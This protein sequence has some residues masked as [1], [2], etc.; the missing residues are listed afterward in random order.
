MDNTSKLLRVVYGDFTLGVHGEG[1]DYIFSYAQGGLESLVKNGY[2]WLYRSPRPTFW[3]ALTDNDRGSK[4]HIKSGSWLAADMFIDCIDVEV[5]TDGISQGKTCAPDNN[6]YGG[7]LFAENVALK[8]VYRTITIPATTVEVRY[9]IDVEGKITVHVSYKGVEGLSELPV[10]GLRFIM[11]TLADKYM[12]EGLSGETYPDRMAGAEHGV[13]EIDDLSLTPYLVPQECG[14]RMNTDWLEVTRHTSLNNS[15]K[16]N[17]EQVLRIEKKDRA[18]AFSCLPYTASEIENAMHQE[19]L[20]SA[21]R[22]VLCVY[23]AV[24]GVGGI[25]SWGSDVEEGYHISAE[26]DITYS[27]VIC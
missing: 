16:D 1:F 3:R 27:F 25:D 15:R 24:R 12:Y 21:R 26:K 6:K 13:Y 19:E 17:T 18:F 11:P 8:Y 23:G 2:E 14:M 5:I 10:F 20:P 7:D 9:S 4:F 22:T